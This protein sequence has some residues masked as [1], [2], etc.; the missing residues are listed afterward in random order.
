VRKPKYASA[1]VAR[2]QASDH[3]SAKAVKT[4]RSRVATTETAI[5]AMNMA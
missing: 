5:I 1:R 2:N 3:R 4:P